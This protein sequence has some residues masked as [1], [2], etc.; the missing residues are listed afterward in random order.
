MEVV[1]DDSRARGLGL[2]APRVETYFERLVSYARE[3][4]WGKRP[5]A[6][7]ELVAA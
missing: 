4:R 5:I 3:A 1:F 7:S 2:R 6:R